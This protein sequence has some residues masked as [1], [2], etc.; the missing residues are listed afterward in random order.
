MEWKLKKNLI[1]FAVPWK[2]IQRYKPE[3]VFCLKMP[4]RFLSQ[5]IS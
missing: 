5:Q 1:L 2:N 4:Q 3:I